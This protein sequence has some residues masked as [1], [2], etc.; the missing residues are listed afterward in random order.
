[1]SLI[2]DLPVRQITGEVAE[3]FRN[4]LKNLP[5]MRG[6]GIY[7]GMSPLQALTTADRLRAALQEP[8]E[9][10]PWGKLSLPR[11]RA[12]SLAAPNS[13]KT[14]NKY[15]TV[16][17]SWGSWM[18][19]GEQ[20]S[21]W[22]HRG[23]CPFAGVSYPKSAVQKESR[24][25]GRNRMSFPKAD[26]CRMLQDTLFVD[27]PTALPSTD[28]EVRLRQAKFW[29]ILIALYTGMRLSEIAMLQARDFCTENGVEIISLVSDATRSFK[30]EAGD[31]KIPLHPDLLKLGLHD[32]AR[33]AKPSRTTR[34]LTGM[35]DSP[36]QKGANISK[37][38]TRWRR[39]LGIE[40]ART[41]F[42][43]FRHNFE[44]ALKAALP[45]ADTL[46]D[47]IIGHKPSSVGAEHYTDPLP[48]RSKDEA[49]A[50]IDF[51]IDLSLVMIA[52]QKTPSGG[53]G[54]WISL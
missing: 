18:E 11:E 19:K 2:G 23:R 4:R 30:T 31:R 1:M 50:K 32:F 42:H 36:K 34:L 52:L 15:L 49:I 46:I 29:S 24:L 51:E 7:A 20:R 5:T 8:G 12:E 43:S 48:I 16:M 10:I 9:T 39:D 33:R 25:A 28:P 54:H 26:L 13:M 53:R 3:T 14:A 38:F 27:P 6:K 21:A 47:Q 41:T 17:T 35:K 37:W 22:L 44:T 40:S 45:G